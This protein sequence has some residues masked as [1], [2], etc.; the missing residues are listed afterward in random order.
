MAQGQDMN[1]VQFSHSVMSN[2]LW[3][4]WTA[5]CQASLS[6][7]NSRSLLKLMSIESVMPS[8]CLILCYPF[9]SCLQSFPASRSFPM[10]QFFASG[11]QSIG[12]SASASV[13]PTN[14]QDWYPLGL[15]IW[16]PGTPRD[17][18]ES[19]PTPQFKSINSLMLWKNMTTGKTIALTRRKF[20]GKVMSLLFNMLS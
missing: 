20:V 10:S 18:Q 5:A 6:I 4:P 13:L 9:S 19:S 8:N 14:I 2:S 16:S 1:S 15:T 11:G 7:I 12:V 3:P 17:S